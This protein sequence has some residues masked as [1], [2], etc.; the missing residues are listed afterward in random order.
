RQDPHRAFLR[1]LLDRIHRQPLIQCFLCGARGSNQCS[2]GC[3]RAPPAGPVIGL[4][5][6]EGNRTQVGNPLEAPERAKRGTNTKQGAQPVWPTKGTRQ[7]SL[8]V[9]GPAGARPRVRWAVRVL[10]IFPAIVGGYARPGL[11]RSASRGGVPGTV[12]DPANAVVVG[13]RITA[14]N[15]AT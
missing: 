13:A 10:I 4:D 9:D 2:L 1:C 6:R 11:A 14:T 8:T 3:L 15:K 7:P 5:E 12:T